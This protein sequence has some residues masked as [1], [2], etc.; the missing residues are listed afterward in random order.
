MQSKVLIIDE[1]GNR[2]EAYISDTL[3]E[4]KEVQKKNWK[5]NL[6]IAST[7]IGIVLSSLLIFTNYSRIKHHQI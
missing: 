5:E 2:K 3:D 4:G 7:V 1:K 6:I